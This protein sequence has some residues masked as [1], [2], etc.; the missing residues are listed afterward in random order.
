[1]A[2]T[3]GTECVNLETLKRIFK[4]YRMKISE[5]ECEEIFTSFLSE[6][7]RTMNYVYMLSP[8]IVFSY[9]IY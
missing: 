5:R 4:D 2:D 7:E 1:M 9:I 8:A 3:K 6:H